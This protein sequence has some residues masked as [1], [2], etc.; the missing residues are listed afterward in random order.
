M[1]DYDALF[2]QLKYDAETIADLGATEND[3]ERTEKLLNWV[4]RQTP[5][6]CGQESVEAWFHD[7][8]CPTYERFL[9]E[10]KEQGGE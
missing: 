8:G 10:Y 2:Q 5:C 7:D 4:A 1:I 6:D 9:Q 3:R